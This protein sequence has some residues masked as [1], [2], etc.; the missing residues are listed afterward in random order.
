MTSST[1]CNLNN[2][3]P[4]ILHCLGALCTYLFSAHSYLLFCFCQ[5]H[6]IFQTLTSLHVLVWC[7]AASSASHAVQAKTT[8]AAPALLLQWAA[9]AVTSPA[10]LAA[11]RISSGTYPSIPSPPPPP[12]LLLWSGLGELVPATAFPKSC[13]C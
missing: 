12:L 11:H 7:I 10:G 6:D 5:Y 13:F 2:I 3:L 9:G 1:S 8:A 4:C